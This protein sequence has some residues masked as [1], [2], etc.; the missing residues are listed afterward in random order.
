MTAMRNALPE[1]LT[2]CGPASILRKFLRDR[3]DLNRAEG[4]HLA[5]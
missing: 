1:F 5:G 2:G 3:I 4:L